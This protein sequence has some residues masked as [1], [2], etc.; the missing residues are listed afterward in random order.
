M[1]EMA[2]VIDPEIPADIDAEMVVLGSMI[3][4]PAAIDDCAWP[5]AAR[6]FTR[7]AHR[8][9]FGAVL[10]VA[11]WG[12]VHG[13]V[14]VKAALERR[15]TLA[16]CGGAV[17]LHTLV[18]SVPSAAS[19]AWYAERVRECAVRWRLAEAGA[20]MRS[21]ALSG[22]ADFADRV[23]QVYRVLEEASGEAAPAGGQ[24]AAD[25][26]G[27][28]LQRIEDG[29]DTRTG[30]TTGWPDLD[31]LVPGLQ[32]GEMI[33]VGARPGV[34]KSAVMLNMATHAAL[35]LGVPV[36]MCSL[37]MSRAEC[38]ERLLASVGRVDLRHIRANQFDDQ[39]WD[40]AQ[41]AHQRIAEA[42]GLIIED[43][44]YTGIQGIRTALRGM[45]RAGTPAQLVVVDYLQLMTEPGRTESRQAEVSALSR[46]LKLLAKEFEVPVV[47]GSQLNRGPEQRSDKRPQPSDL[48]ES[49]S[50]EQDSDIVILLYRE[51]A[52]DKE[53][54]RAGEIDLIV[55]KNR[56]GAQGTVTLT[57]QG[58]YARCA[59]MA[60]VPAPY[61]VG[62][63]S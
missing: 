18:E 45:R 34:G 22:R 48:R 11:D 50:V 58:H 2:A 13:L 42:T 35:G 36:L 39:D 55:A 62:S 28:L 8:E 1:T 53:S 21:A 26:I 47:V 17:Y 51:D 7:P 56:Q 30:I 33:T 63:A 49:G 61:A 25:L 52:H 14:T 38:M 57:F 43:S 12:N 5:V 46:S 59:E 29:P 23:E 41:K 32:P 3:Q 60:R 19:A 31:R 9:I 20:R 10:D 40:R 44:P 6:D 16:K 37:E 54:P 24:L 27:P 15:G 4:S